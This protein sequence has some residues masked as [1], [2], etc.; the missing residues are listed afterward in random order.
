MSSKDVVLSHFG[1]NL[2]EQLRYK[3]KFLRKDIQFE[4]D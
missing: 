1:N 4:I 2:Y 3:Y